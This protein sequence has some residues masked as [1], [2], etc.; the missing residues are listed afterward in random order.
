MLNHF[1][2]GGSVAE[3]IA[4]KAQTLAAQTV[5]Q[6]HV[7]ELEGITTEGARLTK[8]L[9][10]L[11]RIFQVLAE[12]P[13][14]RTPEVNQFCLGTT[15]TENEPRA[16]AVED[17]LRLGVMHLALVRSAGTKQLD[18]RDTRE[19]DYMLHPIL[20]PYFGF[21]HRRKRKL[22]LRTRDVLELIEAPDRAIRR[23][24]GSP[25]LVAEELPEQLMLFEGFYRG[26][27]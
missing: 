6:R 5:G 3:P 7:N 10:G 24:L 1:S 4:P 9:L 25:A 16:G 20:A 21:S 27:G 15:L 11:G 14:H 2:D 23:L 8:L 13:E 12:H 22:E 19:Y 18:E 26:P 17:L